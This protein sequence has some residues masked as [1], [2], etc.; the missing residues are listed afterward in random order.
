MAQTRMRILSET[1]TWIKDPNSLQICWITGM[2]GTGKTSISKTVCEQASGDAEILLGGSFFC[3]R[4]TGLAAQRDIRCVIPTLAQLLAFKS[5]EFRQALA[6]AMESGVQYKE[7]SAQV[8]QLLRTPL[9]TLKDSHIPILF[10]IDAL[11]ECGGETIDGMLDDTKCH[12]IVTSMLEVLVSLT[13]CEPKL[14][15]KF[16]VTSRPEA[17]IHDTFL[18][19]DQLS[20]ILRLHAV[21]AAEVNADISHYITETLNV[22]LSGKPKLRA[23]I[24][25]G[26][27]ENL[28]QL[29]DGLFIIAATALAHVFGAGAAA[30]V[31]KFQKLFNP[32]RNGLNHRVA[33]PLD[34]MYEV[35]LN[36]ATRD[37]DP[38]ATELPTL[39]RLL[40]SLLSARMPLSVA[41]LADLLDLKPYNVGACLSRLHAVVHVPEDEDMPGLRTV[42]ASFGD[43]LYSRAPSHVRIQQPL[44]HDTLAHGCLEVMD[45]L[46]HFNVSQSLS[47]YK[48]NPPL[49]PGSIALSLQ[50]ACMQWAYHIA[51]LYDT[52]N[53]NDKISSIFRPNLLPWLEVMSL[54]RQVLRAS[55]MLF[56]AAGSIH[57]NPDLA[58]FF[59]DANS[60]V[61]SSHEAIERSA[62]HIYL[63]A[64][65]LADKNSLVYKD[66]TPRYTGLI[67]V[68]TFGIG[69]HGGSAVMTLTGHDSAVYSVSYS[70]DGCLLASGSKDGTVRLWDTLT[71]EETISPMRSG[72]EAVLSVDYARNGKWVASGTDA[73]TV[74]IWSIIPGQTSC[75]RL[76]GHSRS[77]RSVAFSLDSSRL[78][79]ASTDK[80]TRL[81]NPE[82]GEQLAVLSGHTKAVTGVAF[83]PDGEI[84]A[85]SS[86]DG[87]IRLWHSTTGHAARE[88]LTNAGRCGVHFSP[89]G[90]MISG[91]EIFEAILTGRTTGERI[92]NLKVGSWNNNR[93]ARFSPDGRL[94]V[95]A[96]ERDVHLW[97][98]Y[99]DLHDA[100][101]VDLGVH[102]GTVNWATFSPDGLYIASASD[103]GTIRIWSAGS[104]QSAVQPMSAH[105]EE[106]QSVVVPHNGASIISGSWDSS[107]RVWNAHTGEATLPPLSGHI[108]MVL[109]VSISPDEELIASGSQDHT[110]Q[111]WDAQS[112][113][114]AGKPLR[115]HTQAVWAVTFSHDGR[116]L[117]S[118]SSDCTARLWDTATRQALTVGP[119][120][121]QKGAN[122]VAL[123]PDDG[124]IAAGDDSGSIYL[125]RT[126]TGE[127]AHE[128]LHA[129]EEEVMS[130][131]FS[132]DGTQ[133]VS[134]GR[135]DVA[136]IW[137]IKAGQC[138][139]ALQ[140]H[141]EVVQSVA[142][143]FDGRKIATGSWDT[144]IRL[145]D[146]VTGAPLATLSGHTQAVTSVVFTNDAQLI[147]SG[148]ADIT[149]RKWD[150]RVACQPV[151]ERGND[152]VTA[153]ASATLTDGWLMGS[154]GEL[155]LW[156]P[157][158]YRAY[159]QVTP[160]ILV[161]GRSRVVIG[162]DYSG[163][164]AGL[165][166]TPCWRD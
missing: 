161:V 130:V 34:R 76:I 11:D 154:S 6:D 26:D 94:L 33:A 131:V 41:A 137:D 98:L 87:S 150:V 138:L 44:G 10:V 91:A 159:L 37:D 45:R 74:C 114:V 97:T 146:A 19:N 61:A 67:T 118:A 120:S 95:V 15:V 152:P 90:E 51:A 105:E 35:I 119:L 110:I 116:W 1:A 70:P 47:S 163:L 80:T 89:D 28:V 83:S 78:A 2:A 16:L 164:H 73:G 30:A 71:G 56:I 25:E 38:E 49:Q 85:S 106:V 100:S 22:K 126:D 64:L 124:I 144:T 31:A 103:D 156:V 7:V 17:Q 123:S 135:D 50:Y 3:S 125:W 13:R 39:Q 93:S 143:S 57:A 21:D 112:G 43:Y 88:P 84:L 160:C 109:S 136:R 121:C 133:I 140:G 134:G 5:V 104:D 79:S 158:E 151:S 115:D 69:Q 48:P 141:T 99:P 68:E 132:P 153:L 96:W 117:A 65:P 142:W 122:T 60:F 20:Q 53:I 113:A 24:T 18:S 42:H 66:F 12:A 145:W 23:S 108:F 58:R 36:E 52:G 62:P 86:E 55:R 92:T 27:V 166:W 4:S 149:I 139:H 147:I 14:P 29:C 111:F 101:W 8:E 9:S 63:S 77:V 82:T 155:I 40:A 72:D 148:S 81:W 165:N 157:A 32:L 128:P 54:L 127:P 129:N 75:R 107:V 102:D 162:V 46:L 59:R